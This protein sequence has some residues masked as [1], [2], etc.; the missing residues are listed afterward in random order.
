MCFV[1]GSKLD[2]FDGNSFLSRRS[3]HVSNIYVSWILPLS[4]D[5]LPF[6][7]IVFVVTARVEMN[8]HHSRY[9]ARFIYSR[10]GAACHFDES[11]GLLTGSLYFACSTESVACCT[12]PSNVVRWSLGS[13]FSSASMFAKAPLCSATAETRHP[14]KAPVAR[15]CH[16]GN[17][18]T[19]HP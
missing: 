14:T 11:T 7:V 17:D 1:L 3:N 16:T 6:L 13:S 10:P 5:A 18:N 9:S 19:N 12:I 15:E 2:V 4:L 8:F